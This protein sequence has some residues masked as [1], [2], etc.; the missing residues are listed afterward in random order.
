MPD[1][2]RT[3]P[4]AMR[5]ILLRAPG[6]EQ[7]TLDQVAKI[8]I[9]RGPEKIEREEGQ[10]RIVVMSNVHGDL[11]SFVSEVRSK[12]DRDLVPRPTF[13]GSVSGSIAHIKKA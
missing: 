8:D 4:D 5:G 12:L 1:R 9:T 11:G 7:V 2:Y 13:C 10:R 3:D 6:G